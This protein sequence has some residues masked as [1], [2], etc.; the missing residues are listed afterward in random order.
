MH[1]HVLSQDELPP[2]VANGVTTIL[3]MGAAPAYMPNLLREE[4]ANG[5]IVG[6]QIFFSLLIVGDAD[7]ARLV[8][9]IAKR[10]R[11]DFIKVYNGVTKP[12]FDAF[13]DEGRKLG[14]PVIGH[15]VRAVSLPEGPFAGQ[16]MVAH[17]E[18]FLY[19]A[20]HDKTDAAAIPALIEAVK[21]SAA[22]VTPNLSTFETIARQWG[23]P[24][25]VTKFLR[26]KEAPY[27]SSEMRL[28]WIES[29]YMK[30]KGNLDEDLAFLRTLTGAMSK[31]QI[32]LLTGTDSPII[33][34]MFPGFSI[35]EDLRTLVQAG[36]TRF[37]ALSAATRTPGAFIRRTKPEAPHFGT[38]AVGHRA[39]LVLVEKNPLGALETLKTPLGVM[40]GGRW[41]ARA[42]LAALMKSMRSRYEDLTRVH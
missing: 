16:V 7:D 31:A 4:N 41:Y 21:R 23:K 40:T 12:E 24:A 33:P 28:H 34:G 26:A 38:V 37:E 30:R 29:N 2:Y 3:H 35:H 1:T 42:K 20:F 22:Y 32:P 17:A 13:V 18:E 14:L 10:N 9:R 6:P 11:Y 36:L 8:V 15:G 39:D 19:T 5:D 25:E 27:V